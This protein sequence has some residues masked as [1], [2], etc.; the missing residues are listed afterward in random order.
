MSYGEVQG[1][2]W[3]SPSVRGL[4][5]SHKLAWSY[6]LSNQH[7]NMLGYYLL[8]LP[9]MADDLEW[10]IEKTEGAIGALE[11]R[12]L[13]A[14]DQAAQIV[15][16]CKYLKYNRL[17]SG[18]RE[19]GALSRLEELAES[20]LLVRLSSAVNEWHPQL[21]DLRAYL[22][23]WNPNRSL[24]GVLEDSTRSPRGDIDIDTEEDRARD[25]DSRCSKM[26]KEDLDALTEH[27]ATI[28]GARPRGKAWLPIQQGFR[29]MVAVE[30]YS[31][32]QVIGCMD[33]LVKLGWTWTINTVRKW[34]CEY[35][36]G[37]MPS[38]NGKKA[39]TPNGRPLGE[40]D[41]HVKEA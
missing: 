32:E 21:A 40:Y 28:R 35:V 18:A 22:E 12:G 30:G 24:F 9:Y 38:D 19:K 10:P 37:T 29:Q 1:K 14:Y 8:P 39:Q 23:N 41:E 6:L 11:K 17:S 31:P 34:I 13:I 7:S 36:A 27:Y 25:V 3:R 33:R 2:T 5:D 26:P 15:F 16:V 4:S 20:P